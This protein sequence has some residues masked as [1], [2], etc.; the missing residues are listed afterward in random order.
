[1]QVVPTYHTP[2]EVNADAVDTEE[3]KNARE[4]ATA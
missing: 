4:R 1:M 2:E 3:M